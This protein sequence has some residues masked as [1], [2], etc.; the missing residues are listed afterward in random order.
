MNNTLES[1]KY[2]PYIAWGLVIGFA[3]FTYALTVHVQEDLSDITVSVARLETKIDNMGNQT[4]PRGEAPS[5]STGLEV[6]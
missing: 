4:I 6:P 2:F 5:P 3:F 1:S